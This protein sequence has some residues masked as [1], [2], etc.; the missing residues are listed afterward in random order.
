VWMR[1]AVKPRKGMC[2]T[3]MVAV[4]LLLVVLSNNKAQVEDTTSYWD[5]ELVAH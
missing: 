1:I 2:G 3:F 4:L 5:E